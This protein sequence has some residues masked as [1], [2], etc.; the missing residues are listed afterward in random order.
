MTRQPG[1]NF[2]KA[3]GKWAAVVHTRG[4]RKHLGLHP[5]QERAYRAQ[6]DYLLVVPEV[7]N[8]VMGRLYE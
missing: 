1:V 2:H 6:Q 8:A 5:T 4:L 3:S 7:V